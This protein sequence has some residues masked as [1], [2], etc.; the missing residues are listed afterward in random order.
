MIISEVNWWAVYLR[1]GRRSKYIAIYRINSAGLQHYI[2]MNCW[3]IFHNYHTEEKATIYIYNFQHPLCWSSVCFISTVRYSIS[4]KVKA[5]AL[6]SPT[7]FWGE[8]SLLTI[9]SILIPSSFHTSSNAIS[10]WYCF[11]FAAILSLSRPFALCPWE[12]LFLPFWVPILVARVP[13]YKLVCPQNIQT[14]LLPPLG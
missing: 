6:P 5:K 8:N 3:M 12:F 11:D 1:I 9:L 10:S 7:L 4:E 14:V 13:I 2:A